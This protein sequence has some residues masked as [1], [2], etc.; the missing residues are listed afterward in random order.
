MQH[1]FV[2]TRIADIT[3]SSEL[4]ILERDRVSRL[5][6]LDCLHVGGVSADVTSQR[7]IHVD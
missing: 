4:K 1:L 2:N 6:L 7:H 5:D 3:V